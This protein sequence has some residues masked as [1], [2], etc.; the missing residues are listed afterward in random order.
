MI[1]IVRGND[2]NIKLLVD[3]VTGKNEQGE[4]VTVPFDLSGASFVNVVVKSRL[5]SLNFPFEIDKNT[6]T[7]H[8]NGR[9]I[10]C[11]DY[12]VEITGYVNRNF[13]SFKHFQFGI[14]ESDEEA[15]V[16]PSSSKSEITTVTLDTHIIIGFGSNGSGI[17]DYLKLTNKPKLNGVELCKN[18]FTT[19]RL[20]V[21][22]IGD[23]LPLIHPKGYV[24]AGKPE[25]R[26]IRKSYASGYSYYVDALGKIAKAYQNDICPIKI[27]TYL[28]NRS[29]GILSL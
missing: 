5:R 17:S 11:G 4:F 24:F 19:N 23:K 6:V 27:S 15:N 2:F 1:K 9:E 18:R 25:Y 26:Q 10:P 20:R 12:A 3:E 28:S 13:R 22:R 14:V 29:W 16:F 8:I 7:V 21:N